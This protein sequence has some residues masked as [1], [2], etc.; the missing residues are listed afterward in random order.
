MAVGRE[1]AAQARI[2]LE[3]AVADSKRAYADSRRAYRDHGSRQTADDTKV[4][5]ESGASSGEAAAGTSSEG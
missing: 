5:D 3:R 4:A 1:A 2:D